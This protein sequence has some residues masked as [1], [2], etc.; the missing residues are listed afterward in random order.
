MIGQLRKRIEILAPA[1]A[2][3]EA[4]GASLLWTSVETVWAGLERLASA[5]DFS[6]D[7]AGHLRR[8]AATI[9]FRDGI[10]LGARLRFDNV[11]YEIVSIESLGDKE[12]FLVLTCEEAL[13]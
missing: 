10:G 9:R 5:R 7:R 12:R 4:G 13:S 11:D 2:P 6:G 3:D 1:R 8:L